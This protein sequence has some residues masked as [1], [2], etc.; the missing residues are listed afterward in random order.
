MSLAIL[1][2]QK[3][4]RRCFDRTVRW[5]CWSC[6][7]APPTATQRETPLYVVTECKVWCAMYGWM[8]GGQQRKCL[9]FGQFLAQRVGAWPLPEAGGSCDGHAPTRKWSVASR[10]FPPVQTSGLKPQYRH[11][12]LDLTSSRLTGSPDCDA[13]RRTTNIWTWEQLSPNKLPD[14]YQ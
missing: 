12:H 6:D 1:I 14:K 7:L 13:P 2:S 10:P 3:W 5:R 4:H 9:K 11:L 8:Y